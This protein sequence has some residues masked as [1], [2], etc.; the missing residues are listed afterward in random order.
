MKFI[1]YTRIKW[2]HI[3]WLLISFL[4]MMAF[5]RLTA[6]QVKNIS[7]GTEVL[8][9][10]FGNTV[11]GIR[12]TMDA[13][14]NDGRLYYLT[15]FLVIDFFY[16]MVYAAFYFCT[17]LFLLYKNEI[18]SGKVINICWFPV[19][20]MFFDWAENLLL[21][22]IIVKWPANSAV[23]C[24]MLIVSN[25]TKFLLVYLS[26]L[27]VVLLICYA[28]LKRNKDEQNFL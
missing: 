4:C 11:G 14:G 18:G 13:L 25:I 3:F 27:L 8:G 2:K 6:L 23:L 12:V 7:G 16:A 26:L 22:V 20:G 1:L 21:S 24:I 15:H 19:A 9:L 5:M 28:I 10:H 17:I